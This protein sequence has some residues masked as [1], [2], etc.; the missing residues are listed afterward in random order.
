[1][2]ISY[3]KQ[4]NAVIQHTYLQS[5][6]I[7]K[8]LWLSTLEAMSLFQDADLNTYLEYFFW[9]IEKSARYN[10]FNFPRNNKTPPAAPYKKTQNAKYSERHRLDCVCSRCVLSRRH[11]LA[12]L[13]PKLLD[14]QIPCYKFKIQASQRITWGEW[15]LLWLGGLGGGLIYLRRIHI[16]GSG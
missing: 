1:M 4:P 2:T 8:I 14:L 16:P 10:T 15:I 7:T 11:P 12:P 5:N 3:C 6:F 9:G 13:S